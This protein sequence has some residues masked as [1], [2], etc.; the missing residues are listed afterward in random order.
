MSIRCKK[1]QRLSGVCLLLFAIVFFAGGCAESNDDHSDDG[2]RLPLNLTISINRAT[3]S[4]SV[5]SAP[6][7]DASEIGLISAFLTPFDPAVDGCYFFGNTLLI[8]LTLEATDVATDLFSVHLQLTDYSSN[9]LRPL[10]QFPYVPGFE[11]LQGLQLI[12][13]AY[14]GWFASYAYG[15]FYSSERAYEFNYGTLSASTW[16]LAFDIT[17]LEQDAT[18]EAGVIVDITPELQTEQARMTIAPYLNNITANSVTIIWETDKETPADLWYGR[19][20]PSTQKFGT[21]RRFQDSALAYPP[22][23]NLNVHEVPLSGLEPGATYY[24]QI[25]S[26]A[27]ASPVYF[28]RTLAAAPKPSFKFAVYADTRTDDIPHASVINAMVNIRDIHDYDFAVH[29]GDFNNNFVQATE[30]YTFFGI[31]QPLL[32]YVCMF[33]VRGNHDAFNAYEQYFVVPPAGQSELENHN[34]AFEYQGS[35]FIMIDSEVDPGEGG[36]GYTWMKYQLK[37]AKEDPDRTFTF[38]F[39]HIPYYAGWGHYNGAEQ[40]EWLA[41]LFRDNDVSAGFAGHIHLY[42]RID[43]SGKPW[44]IT[45]SAGAPWCCSGTTPSLELLAEQA[46]YSQETV[47]DKYFGWYYEFLIVEVFPDKFTIYAYDDS[48]SGEP[49]DQ[50]TFIK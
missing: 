32:S 46:L 12:D 25:K 11:S 22:V 7:L 17:G 27:A 1:A 34:Y 31:E 35:H 30:R 21:T 39:S 23:F 10:E 40:L 4:V 45:G 2:A 47:T 50:V 13:P 18:I 20:Q 38:L 16:V 5:Q 42:E 41:P 33:P 19:E 28:F 14:G 48:G 49:F 24:Y 29:I 26:L 37:Q 36:V 15:D 9:H 8:F 6:G 43:V 44:I 3:E